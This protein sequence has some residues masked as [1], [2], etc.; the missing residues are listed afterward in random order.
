MNYSA[1]S[2]FGLS[3]LLTL[4]QPQQHTEED[5]YS[6]P[7]KVKV[8]MTTWT[9]YWPLHPGDYLRQNCWQLKLCCQKLQVWQKIQLPDIFWRDGLECLQTIKKKKKIYVQDTPCYLNMHLFCCFIFLIEKND[10]ISVPNKYIG[11]VRTQGPTI[12]TK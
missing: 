7:L 1:S 12:T 8:I 4:R 9:N 11:T 6:S 5:I 2:Y 3:V 10:S